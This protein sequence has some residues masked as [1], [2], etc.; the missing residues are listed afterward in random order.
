[1]SFGG[2]NDKGIKYSMVISC[3]PLLFYLNFLLVSSSAD[4]LWTDFFIVNNIYSLFAPFVPSYFCYFVLFY[5]IFFEH[6][7]LIWCLCCLLKSVNWTRFF[8]TKKDDIWLFLKA[9]KKNFIFYCYLLFDC[10]VGYFQL[11]FISE[12]M[13]V[14]GWMDYVISYLLLLL[15]HF[16]F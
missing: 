1:M 13:V 14:D 4:D 16:Y 2:L 9:D 7:I 15:L 6:F 8:S 5:Y 3:F 10:L 11:E 12:M